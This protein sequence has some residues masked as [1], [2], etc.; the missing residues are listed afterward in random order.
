M[1][2]RWDGL[3]I[4]FFLLHEAL[5]QTVQL[6]VEVFDLPASG[7]ALVGVH[8][9]GPH[10]HQSPLGAAHDRGRHLQIAQQ[11]S[12]PCGG[13]VRFRGSLGFEKQLGLVE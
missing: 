11:S 9:G 10:A 1:V 2:V 7:L 12:G 5:R 8:F 6:M 3:N 4:G 13:G